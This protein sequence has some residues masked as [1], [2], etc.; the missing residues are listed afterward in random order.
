MPTNDGVTKDEVAGMI[1]QALN[2]REH[3]NQYQ[4]SPIA[5][6]SHTGVDSPQVAGENLQFLDVVTNNASSLMH[7][8]LRK[9]DGNTG[10]FL[11]G[12]GSWATVNKFGGDGSD[13]ALSV[14]SGTTTLSFGS[15]AVLVKNYT[16]GT[17]TGGTLTAS[18][19]HSG[20]S[21]L[22]L[23]FQ[24]NLTFT[25]GSINLVGM[26]ASA[27]VLPNYFLG[28][29]AV[30]GV[31]AIANVGGAG[32]AIWDSVRHYL[33]Y[34]GVGALS[35]R[36]LILVPGAASA[37]GADG[38]A[39]EAGG[40]AVRG[41][42]AV[43]IEVGGSINYTVSGGIIVSGAPG[44][45]GTIGSAV[46]N[47][48]PGAGG[49]GGGSA[50]MGLVLY[51]TLTAASGT[52]TA[53]GGTGGAGG[54]IQSS[55]TGNVDGAGGG[56]GG[57][58]LESAGGTGGTGTNFDGG[59]GGTPSAGAGGGGGAGAGGNTVSGGGTAGAG[60]VGTSSTKNWL[61]AKNDWFV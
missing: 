15:V 45:A 5:G 39:G 61:I 31:A 6:H 23:R 27:G 28:S 19:P 21:L 24:S 3:R 8:F 14:T 17:I 44:I 32:G 50:G 18:N 11:R 20:G 48:H 22:V 46:G 9:L 12:D 43:L 55:L 4:I 54:A 47:N 40:A 37:A 25:G 41:G 38:N 56:G 1:E 30:Y 16:T 7:G 10:H 34:N 26:G 35:Q 52:I 42:G 33:T 2:D 57:G 58:G 51:N 60:G 49:S 53:S 13:G 29:A 59:A 36:Y